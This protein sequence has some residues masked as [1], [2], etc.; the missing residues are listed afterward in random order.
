MATKGVLVDKPSKLDCKEL[1]T[2]TCKITKPGIGGP[3][4][5][6]R[7]NFVGMNFIDDNETPYL[8]RE[9]IQELLRNF[10]A[11]GYVFDKLVDFAF[12]S[13]LDTISAFQR[14][15]TVLML[16]NVAFCHCSCI[17][18]ISFSLRPTVALIIEDFYVPSK[19]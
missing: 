7:G 11:N 14:L 19:T 5:N 15:T 1:G 6:T 4:I 3:L 10:D 16:V 9:K 17:S 13:F 12:S 2:S 18:L 8:P